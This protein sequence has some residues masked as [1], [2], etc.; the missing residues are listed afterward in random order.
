[1]L[2]S[3]EEYSPRQFDR[4]HMVI[5][6]NEPGVFEFGL[7]FDGVDIV[8]EG[9]VRAQVELQDLLAAQFVRRLRLFILFAKSEILTS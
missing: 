9:T 7:Q 2:L 5:S 1:M 4:I 8:Q 3:I 6:S